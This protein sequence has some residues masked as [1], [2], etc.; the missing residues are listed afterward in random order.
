MIIIQ[1]YALLVN[2]KNAVIQYFRQTS[3]QNV[4]SVLYYK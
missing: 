2:R 1:P 3:L 4:K